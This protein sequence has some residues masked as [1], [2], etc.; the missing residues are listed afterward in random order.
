ML[1]IVLLCKYNTMLHKYNTL[2]NWGYLMKGVGGEKKKV[3]ILTNH[4]LT[5]FLYF[6]KTSLFHRRAL[7]C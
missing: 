2:I 5:K 1:L 6:L 3:V 7:T 4:T